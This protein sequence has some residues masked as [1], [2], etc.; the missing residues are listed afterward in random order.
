M[1]HLKSIMLQIGEL[2]SEEPRK[3]TKNTEVPP[4]ISIKLNQVPPQ[5][6]APLTPRPDCNHTDCRQ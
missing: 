5:A 6:A 4:D 1:D 3:I 2:F